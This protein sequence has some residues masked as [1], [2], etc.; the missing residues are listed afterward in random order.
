MKLLTSTAVLLS[1]AL[2]PIGA[3]AEVNPEHHKSCLEARDYAGCIKA[4]SGKIS[5]EPS[6]E[7]CWERWGQ[8]LCI[9]KKGV[10]HFGLPK[11]VGS[12]YI[13]HDNGHI[14]YIEWDGVRQHQDGNPIYNEYLVPHKG[15]KRY[16]AEKTFLR[17]RYE[18]RP[19]IPSS[20]SPGWGTPIHIPGRVG[21]PGGIRTTEQIYIYD[22]KDRTSARY[23]NGKLDGGWHKKERSDPLNRSCNDYDFDSMPILRM[24]L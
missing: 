3:L 20:S 23:T 21:R 17:W 2:A 16:I 18:G 6:A 12:I 24:K 9:A 5:E 8:D 14:D 10:D 4:M 13:I 19:S 7:R 1:T 22:C 11:I 15:Q